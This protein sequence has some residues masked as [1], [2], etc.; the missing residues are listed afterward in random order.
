[1][2]RSLFVGEKEFF[3]GIGQIQYESPT[4]DSP[5]SFKAYEADRVVA[6]KTMEDHLRFHAGILNA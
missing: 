4:S 5:L 2:S 3:P 6:G 1:M